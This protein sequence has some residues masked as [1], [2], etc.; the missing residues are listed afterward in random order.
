MCLE[1]VQLSTPNRTIVE[2][3]RCHALHL[4]SS[5]VTE[6]PSQVL[7]DA[8]GFSGGY[9]LDVLDRPK[10]CEVHAGAEL[11]SGRLAPPV[12]VSEASGSV[13]SAD[14]PAMASPVLFPKLPL[15][16]LAARVAG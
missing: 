1:P 13:A 5:A 15:Q 6:S 16:D 7:P 2:P 4:T 12:A 9:D 14:A 11:T 3:D 8:G 10:D